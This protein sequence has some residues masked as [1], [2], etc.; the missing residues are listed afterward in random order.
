MGRV[1]FSCSTGIY[2]IGSFPIRRYVD[3]SGQDGHQDPAGTS[4]SVPETEDSFVQ[5]GL[6]AL[7]GG[8]VCGGVHR[9]RVFTATQKEGQV[10]P[11]E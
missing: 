6:R 9:V 10:F 2:F 1:I 3:T 4:S 8:G 11:A 7:M 5:T